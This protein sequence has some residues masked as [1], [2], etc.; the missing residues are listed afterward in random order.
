MWTFFCRLVKLIWESCERHGRWVPDDASEQS[1]PGGTGR[2]EQ[3]RVMENS[4]SYQTDLL[5]VTNSCSNYLHANETTHIDT[6][7]INLK[8][9]LFKNVFSVS[10]TTYFTIKCSLQI[11]KEVEIWS[12]Y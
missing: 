6:Y 8:F 2:G 9:F 7:F 5:H 3:K 10:F 12:R 1:Q 11:R 4:R